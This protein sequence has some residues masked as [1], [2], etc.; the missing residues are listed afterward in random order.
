MPGMTEW[1]RA[2]IKQIAEARGIIIRRASPVTSP[3]ARLG[4][5]TR[6]FG[7]DCVLDVGANQGQYG[8]LLRKGGYRGRIISFEPLSRAHALL[9]ERA[10]TD[11]S[12][13][14]YRRCALGRERGSAEI[15]VAENSWSSSLLPM[16]SRHIEAAPNSQPTSREPVEIEILDEVLDS[17]GPF[18]QRTFL[19]IDT[20]GF[21]EQVLDGAVRTLAQAAVVELEASLVPLYAGQCSW[22]H[23]VERM[24]ESG[25]EV[26]AIEPEFSDPVSGQTLQVDLTFARRGEVYV[27]RSPTAPTSG[28]EPAGHAGSPAS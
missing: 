20:Q 24:R 9:R 12:W 15:Q 23:L 19:K 6:H 1:V 10:S 3:A 17:V 14:V 5:L 11:S 4:A 21:E 8:A 26:W 7:V 27:N 16:L 2:G 25:F 13:T 18:G 22:K 28:A